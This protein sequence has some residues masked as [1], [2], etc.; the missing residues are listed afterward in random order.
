MKFGHFEYVV[1]NYF[2]LNDENYFY[3][4]DLYSDLLQSICYIDAFFPF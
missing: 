4:S 1:K 2:H 3:V